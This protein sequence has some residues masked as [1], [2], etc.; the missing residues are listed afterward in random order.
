MNLIE[1]LTGDVD[2]Q[3]LGQGLDAMTHQQRVAATRSL[4]GKY[5]A[6][7][8]E[9]VDGLRPVGLEHFVPQG[10][11][12]GEVVTHVGTNTL[13]TFRSFEKPM[14]RNNGVICGRNVQFW[15]FLTGPGYFTVAAEHE[16]GKQGEVVL[17][18]VALP[19]GKPDGWPK[20]VTNARG[21][22]HL[23]FKGLQDVMRG[24]S[25]HVTIGRATRGGKTMEEYFIL[26]RQE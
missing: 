4:P 25:T 10:I 26:V 3:A 5:F 6:K 23:V 12:D 21:F 15:S 20:V 18:Y 7:L 1:Q 2:P 17:D 24:V 9:A 22:S 14:Y 16:R 8:F 19:P 13:P 11:A